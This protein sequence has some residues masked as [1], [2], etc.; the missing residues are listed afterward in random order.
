MLLLLLWAM[1]MTMPVFGFV[2]PCTCT[3]TLSACTSFRNSNTNG[4]SN[5]CWRMYESERAA[6]DS[7]IATSTR[8]KRTVSTT[9]MLFAS[10]NANSN[11]NSN[12]N[13]DLELLQN[14]PF[15]PKEVLSKFLASSAGESLTAANLQ[16][17]YQA[18]VVSG[19]EMDEIAAR[20]PGMAGAASTA[21]TTLLPIQSIESIRADWENAVRNQP[22]HVQKLCN[23]AA[24]TVI[25][26]VAKLQEKA[27]R[28]ANAMKYINDEATR[29]LQSNE[30]IVQ[31]L[32]NSGADATSST[33]KLRF[34]NTRAKYETD[35]KVWSASMDVFVS[36]EQQ[37]PTPT[38][39]TTTTQTPT[40]SAAQTALAAMMEST[41]DD[42]ND[43]LSSSFLGSVEVLDPSS[44]TTTTTST[45]MPSSSSPMGLVNAYFVPEEEIKILV[46]EID[47]VLHNVTWKG[48]AID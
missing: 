7:T 38:T 42:D 1:T 30:T 25:G 5:S 17:G 16:A 10:P 22:W 41:D 23:L 14:L 9:P 8:R 45:S 43:D 36:N 28:Q 15:V 12:A 4:N 46:V 2:L 35:R 24:P 13:D 31:L 32:S 3:N 37:T 19:Q 11:A 47:G 21:S 34:N 18:G 27:V 33:T 20:M 29:V 26:L 44:S 6:A 39:T 40:T 48:L